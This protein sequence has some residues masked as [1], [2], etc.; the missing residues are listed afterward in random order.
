[1]MRA[2]SKIPSSLF[3]VL[4][5]GLPV[6]AKCPLPEGATLIVRA[7]VGDLHVETNG[8]EPTVEVQ[9]ENNAIQVQE[10][11]GKDVVQFTGNAPDQIRGV[12]AWRIIAPRTV[13]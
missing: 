1:M 5:C 6:L 8:S 7:A 10:N 3:L 12:V 2:T 9:V 13:N 4:V 11:C